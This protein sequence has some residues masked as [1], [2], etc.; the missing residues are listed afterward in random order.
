MSVYEMWK[1]RVKKDAKLIARDTKDPDGPSIA[2]EVSPA[3]HRS[4][5]IL[6]N[7]LTAIS[8]KTGRLQKERLTSNAMRTLPQVNRIQKLSHQRTFQLGLMNVL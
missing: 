2:P 1:N 5:G 8:S 7:A 4:R 6:P 3:P